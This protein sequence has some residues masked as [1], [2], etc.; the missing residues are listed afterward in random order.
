MPLV[1]FLLRK[2][3]YITL[4]IA[5]AGLVGGLC[6]ATLIAIINSSLHSGD[7]MSGLMVFALIGV[8]FSKVASGAI[9]KWLMARFA[10]TTFLDLTIDL[11]RKIMTVPLQRLEQTGTYR[12][13]TALTTDT[14]VLLAAAQSIPSLVVNVAVVIGCGA[15]LVW[16]Y[17]VG[18]VA[19]SVVVFFGVAVYKLIHTTAY[20]AVFAQRGERDKLVLHYRSLVDGIKELKMHRR[21]GEELL[22]Q[23]IDTTVKEVRRLNLIARTR[24]VI[25]DAWNQILFYLMIAGILFLFPRDGSTSLEI[26]TGYIFASLYVMTPIWSIIG[27]IPVFLNGQVSLGKLEEL[28]VLLSTEQDEDSVALPESA[29]NIELELANVEF[30]YESGGGDNR[31]PFH[32]GPVDLTVSP[33]EILFIVGGNG[34][35]KSTLVK[36]LAGLYAPEDG[37]I[38][39]GGQ[40]VTDANRDW[41]RQHISVV[42]SDFYLFDGLLGESAADV[43]DRSNTFL[44]K[45][46]LDHKVKVTDRMFSTV[47]LSQGQRKRLAMLTSLIEDRP[48]NIFDEWAADQDPH[49]KD[50]FYSRLLPELKAQ[51]KTVIVITHD[52]RYFN[53]GDRV[54]KLQDG[55]ITPQN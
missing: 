9:T 3:K 38:K 35:G 41:Y 55:E 45:L 19:L 40:P 21:R 18:F 44:K 23:R 10:L 6:S 46:E 47:E 51:G 36:L 12:I 11:S 20:N 42:F 53:H 43:D 27:T 49:Y 28:G 13:F 7:S 30:H 17:P 2:S 16:L 15:Y 24:F 50:I 37:N 48:I 8:V 25:L 26:L 39:L 1:R 33:G 22:A 14:N 29:D 4:A 31:Y 34:S 52:D 54:I 5:L 32:L